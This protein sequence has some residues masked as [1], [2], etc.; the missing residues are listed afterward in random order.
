VG[1]GL[2]Y[3]LHNRPS[4]IQAVQQRLLVLR[5]HLQLQPHASTL[6]GEAR[7]QQRQHLQPGKLQCEQ[8]EGNV[9]WALTPEVC[10]VRQSAQA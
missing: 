9:S 6:D 8:R 2:L 10:A 3:A 5:R 7:L 1:T 4:C